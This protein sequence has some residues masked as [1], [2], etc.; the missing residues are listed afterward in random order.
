ML[1]GVPKEIKTREFR[2]GLVPSSVA[3]LVRRGHKVLIETQAGAGIGANDDEYKAVGATITANAA[4]V[5]ARADMI[6]KVKEPQ[7]QE[8]ALIKNGQTVFTYFHFAADKDL[9]LG[10]LER[11]CISVANR[12]HDGNYR[13]NNRYG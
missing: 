2:V 9:T 11:G 5:F 12:P 1:I 6:V 8:V 10:C 3:E 4:D 7:P 13:G